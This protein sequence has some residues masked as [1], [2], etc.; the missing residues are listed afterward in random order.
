MS[1]M[2]H[3]Y[4]EKP[5]SKSDPHSFQIELLGHQLTFTTDVG[6]FSKRFLDFGTKLLIES[7]QMPGVEGPLLDVGCGYGPIGVSLAKQAPDRRVVMV[8]INERA[9]SLAEKNCQI[10]DIHNAIVIKSDLFNDVPD[11]NYA[12]ILSNPP[13]RAGKKVVY[14]LFQNAYEFLAENGE[15]WC[16]IQKKQ[17]ASSA[18]KELQAIFGFGNVD[19]INKKKGYFI[20]RSKKKSN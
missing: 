6:V 7:F 8:D 10:N 9:V 14:Q 18:E 20:F 11:E 17:G 16:V 13:I 1:G 12:A 2:E 15:F 5:T 4:S 19:V 3:Y